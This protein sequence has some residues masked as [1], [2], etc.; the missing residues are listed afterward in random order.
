LYA[1]EID[2][3]LTYK[4][5]AVDLVWLKRTCKVNLR[6]GRG[7]VSGQGGGKNLPRFA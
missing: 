6:A 1:Y 2:L 4:S 5:K 3:W 7:R